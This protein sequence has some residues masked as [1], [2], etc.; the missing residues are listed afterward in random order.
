MSGT[1]FV[2]KE[3]H[4]AMP[5]VRQKWYRTFLRPILVKH[6]HDRTTLRV[7]TALMSDKPANW[8]DH[9]ASAE[10]AWLTPNSR[11]AS[12]AKECPCAFGILHPGSV[13]RAACGFELK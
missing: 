8:R 11:N 7:A 2:R 4:L 5:M 3:A 13:F 12:P 10:L 1:A 9:V 6:V